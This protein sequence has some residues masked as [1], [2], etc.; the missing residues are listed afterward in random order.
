MLLVFIG[1]LP[2]LRFG[3]F[4]LVTKSLARGQ[5]G[6][7]LLLAQPIL[8]A[9]KEGEADEP[10]YLQLPPVVLH[11]DGALIDLATVRIED[12]AAGPAVVIF[13]EIPKNAKSDQR[14]AFQL[15]LTTVA[16]GYRVVRIRVDEFL[17]SPVQFALLL[18]DAHHRRFLARD[19]VDGLP[20]ANGRG[21]GSGWGGW[22]SMRAQCAHWRQKHRNAYTHKDT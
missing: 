9:A 3:Q 22:F 1:N 8:R 10:A 13:L 15:A 18:P 21:L 12:P 14:L 16:P 4:N 19:V 6:H 11:C 2:S 7:E 20:S 17:D 5:A